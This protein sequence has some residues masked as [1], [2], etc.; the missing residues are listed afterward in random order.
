M[1][2]ILIVIGVFFINGGIAQLCYEWLPRWNYKYKNNK[3]LEK[4]GL[5]FSFFSPFILLVLVAIFLAPK[6]NLRHYHK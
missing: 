6:K 2:T 1:T 5:L 3:V 4:V